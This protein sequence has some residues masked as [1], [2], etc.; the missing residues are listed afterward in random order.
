MGLL[1][2]NM[3]PCN[4]QRVHKYLSWERD[5]LTKGLFLFLFTTQQSRRHW[6]ASIYEVHI[7]DSPSPF[8]RKIY[9]VC[10]QTCCF[11]YLLPLLC[12]CHIWKSPNILPFPALPRPRLQD[13][14]PLSGHDRDCA[15]RLSEGNTGISRELITA[16]C[17]TLFSVAHPLIRNILLNVFGKIP[18]AG[19]PI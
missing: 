8:V 17:R 11:F 10:P 13:W 12:G 14:I 16:V 9:T 7:W 18:P 15:W 19:G 6:G 5:C 3:A 2:H 4:K 1:S